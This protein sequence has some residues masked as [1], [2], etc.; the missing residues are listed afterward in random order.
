M[1]KL[2]QK[3]SKINWDDSQEL[4]TYLGSW[5]H[6]DNWVYL[7]TALPFYT[8]SASSANWL[9]VHSGE[10][11]RISINVSWVIARQS[12]KPA[13]I[14]MLAAIV[15]EN[16]LLSSTKVDAN[17]R[18]SF[19][20]LQAFDQWRKAAVGTNQSAIPT[21]LKL[22]KSL[23]LSNWSLCHEK[24]FIMFVEIFRIFKFRGHLRPVGLLFSGQSIWPYTRSLLM[25]A[26]EHLML[27]CHLGRTILKFR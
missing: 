5:K 17:D 19:I 23:I 4:C 16:L 12:I 7:L 6:I 25:T 2:S 15:M 14:D 8:W 22:I 24:E 10:T 13:I 1:E 20:T 26:N 9:S 27:C 21:R 11:F 3:W 18:R